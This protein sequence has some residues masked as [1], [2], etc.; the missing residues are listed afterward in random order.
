MDAPLQR[1]AFVSG[2]SFS[3]IPVTLLR[4]KQSRAQIRHAMDHFMP[5]RLELMKRPPLRSSLADPL[6]HL[7][8]HFQQRIC[9]ERI[10]L[11]SLGL[12]GDA[13]H[14]AFLPLKNEVVIPPS[15]QRGRFYAPSVSITRFTRSPQLQCG[16]PDTPSRE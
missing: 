6:A 7:A 1:H 16:L 11:A 13:D 12:S 10:A 5:F 4:D 9:R 3:Q 8:S 14:S 15:S 2:D